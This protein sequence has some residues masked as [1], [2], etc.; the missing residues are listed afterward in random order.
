MVKAVSKSKAIKYLDQ[1]E[2]FL[3]SSRENMALSRFNVSAFNAIQAMINANDA[4]TI[5]YLERRGSADHGEAL[6]LHLDVTRKINDGSQRERLKQCLSI[7]NNAGYM[8]DA[9]SRANAE[10]ALR[11]AVIF[12][13]WVK[14]YLK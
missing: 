10:K 13:E 12:I 4:L 11:S 2:E 3:E 14:R 7:R 1:A 9:I 8:G 6:D 5:Y